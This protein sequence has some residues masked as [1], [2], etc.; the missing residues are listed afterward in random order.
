MGV[1]LPEDPE[2]AEAAIVVGDRW[3]GRGAGSLLAEILAEAA[4]ERG[5]RRFSA[6]ML[7][8]NLRA[9]RL[10]ERLAAGLARRHVGAGTTE[11]VVDLAA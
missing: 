9:Q 2:T 4:P 6:T 3:Q 8:D 5:V 7:R 10:M 11:T 1:R